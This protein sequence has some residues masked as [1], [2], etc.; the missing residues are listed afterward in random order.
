MAERPNVMGSVSY[1]F[2]GET[3]VVTGGSSGIGRAIALRFGEA[4]A[5]VVNAD[6]QAN[7]KDEGADAPTHKKIREEGGEAAFVECDVTD[8]DAIRA[9]VDRARDYGGVDVMVNNAG[10]FERAPLEEVTRESFDRVYDVNAGGVFFGCQAA[11]EDMIERGKG[12]VVVNTAS[13]SSTHA[14]E[15]QIP[16]DATKGAIKMI[17]RGAALELADRDVRVNAVAPG[18]IATEFGSGAEKKKE[19]VK[20][21]DLTKP[22]PLGR[23]GV[24]EDIAGAVLFL[25]SEEADYVTGELLYVDGGWQA[26]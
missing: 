22:V 7:P 1:D 9:A 17:T 14:Q 5:A 24:P 15:S 18:H 2:G 8:T 4:G 23:A 6:L 12:G 16:Y 11:A 20:A 21:G 25:A 19:A 3:V 13:I 10:L 26:F